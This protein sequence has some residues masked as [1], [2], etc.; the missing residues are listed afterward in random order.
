MRWSFRAIH[1]G[2]KNK[3]SRCKKS[4]LHNG[5]ADTLVLALNWNKKTDVPKFRVRL[6]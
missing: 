4:L 2:H 5:I 6:R 3:I 1:G